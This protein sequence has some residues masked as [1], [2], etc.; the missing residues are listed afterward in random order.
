MR[1]HPHYTLI[2]MA[3][4][5]AYCS[6]DANGY[7]R[8]IPRHASDWTAE[9]DRLMCALIVDPDQAAD[10]AEEGE[11]IPH[12]FEA[13]SALGQKG[14]T[15]AF[16]TIYQWM[17]D[18]SSLS[19]SNKIARIARWDRFL[20]IYATI[21]LVQKRFETE[22]SSSCKNAREAL[23]SMAVIAS[24]RRGYWK[25]TI[26]DK[27]DQCTMVTAIIRLL[28]QA[29]QRSYDHTLVAEAVGS[30]CGMILSTMRDLSTKEGEKWLASGFCEGILRYPG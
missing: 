10:A 1:M 19:V 14:K 28:E 23:Q 9:L 26:A 22:L 18:P 15:S 2:P 27:E 24:N 30:S 25:R 8:M 21:F 7:L 11:S 16:I 20:A 12:N 17:M 6:R 13:F 29:V 4:F 5:E 3:S